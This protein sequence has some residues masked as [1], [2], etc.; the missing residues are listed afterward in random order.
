[1]S[2]LAVDVEDEEKHTERQNLGRLRR[3]IR[4][5]E[6]SYYR[7]ILQAIA[8]M[9]GSG[10][11]RDVLDKVEKIMKDTL[12]PVDFEPLASD[13]DNPRWR[14]A[15]QWARNTMVNEG[16]LKN[17]S[18]RGFWEISDTGRKYL[19]NEIQ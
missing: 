1:M 13:P 3:G 16:L 19:A 14:N 2:T 17:D 8:E 10:R 6:E 12:K 5:R 15:A 4:T 9:G 7:P 18:P 11:M